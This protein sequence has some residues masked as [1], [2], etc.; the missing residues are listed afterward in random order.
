MK[1]V[2]SH[3]KT[4]DI[5][6]EELHD[7]ALRRGSVMVQVHASV[8]SA[9]TERASISDRKQSLLQKARKNPDLVAKV[10]QDVRTR[11]LSSTYRRV[12]NRLES[13]AGTGYSAAGRIVQLGEGVDD[14]GVGDMVACAG[15]AYANHAEVIVVP[16]NLC[17]RVPEGVGV[18]DAAY[19]T[20]AAI[21]LQGI[22]QAEVR[23]GES[24]AVIGL[25]LVGQLTVQM[26]KAS[27][28][29]VYGIDTEPLAVGLAK[30][31]GADGAFL[32]SEDIR[33]IIM[34]STAGSGADAVIITAATR[35]EDPVDLAG[36]V[37]RDRGKV[38]LVGDVGLSIPR[39]PYYMKELDFRLSRSYGPG[40]YDPEYEEEG[41]DYPIGYVRWT[42]R[43]NMGEVL[44]LMKEQK[45]RP[46][47][48]TTHTFPLGEAQK[49]FDTVTGKKRQGGKRPFGVVLTYGP[50]EQKA[51]RRKGRSQ[52]VRA[53]TGKPDTIGFIGAGSFAQST[54]LPALK[55]IDGVRLQ[56]VCTGTGVSAE[57][58]KRQFGFA[59]GTTNLDDVLDDETIGTVFIASRHFLHG[60]QVMASL[61]A[62]KHVFVEKPL[63]MRPE[64]LHELVAL[65]A[66]LP[67]K[68]SRVIMAGFNRRFAPSMSEMKTFFSGVPAPFT[69]NYRVH[70]GLLPKGHWSMSED[71]GG[72]RIVGEICHFIDTIQFLTGSR[73]DR[74][75][76]ER[77]GPVG[78]TLGDDSVSIML[79]LSDGSVGNISYLANGDAGVPKEYIEMYG[80]GRTAILDNFTSLSLFEGAKKKERSWQTVDKGHDRELRAMMAAVVSM[81]GAPIPFTDAVA[82]TRTTFRIEESL[83]RGTPVAI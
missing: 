1:Q 59:T 14:L 9:G 64:E 29:V 4:G 38:V 76:A 21:A 11:G 70:A 23:L 6:I 40:R 36:T 48:L 25:G 81:G 24:V 45:L 28:C 27:G 43:R 39:T 33:S 58:I 53:A 32:R 35:S 79:K 61:R 44:R 22:R 12:R 72:G 16:K 31:S 51:A 69:V 17:A 46:S 80:G 8:I 7:P 77:V 73:V 5:R 75:Y 13:F 83:R 62:G 42:E 56:T 30:Q 2:V 67:D 47:L 71:E 52:E 54:L 55:G 18:E 37:A 20:I 74:V 15:A 3:I 41:R 34:H 66:A 57:N 65:Q 19:T 50:Q 82:V 63:V 10:I 26:L 60:K 68:E 49:A 78:A